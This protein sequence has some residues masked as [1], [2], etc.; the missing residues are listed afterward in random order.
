MPNKDVE[1]AKQQVGRS[2]S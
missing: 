2:Y 1:G